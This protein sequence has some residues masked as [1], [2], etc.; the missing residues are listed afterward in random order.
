MRYRALS[1]TG[2][3]VFGRGANQ[4]LVSSPEAVGQAVL[5][6]LRLAVGE[7]YLDTTEGTQYATKILGE[8]TMPLYDQAVRERIL[9]TP[10]VKFIE[11]YASFLDERRR[12]TVSGTIMTEFSA[13]GSTPQAVS[14]P[15]V[16]T[17]GALDFTFILDQSQLAP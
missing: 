14:P 7:W 10:G 15:A 1:P 11:K 2:D 8:R 12:L 9:G 16:N 3:Y 17:F 5:T 4:F 13:G 6:R